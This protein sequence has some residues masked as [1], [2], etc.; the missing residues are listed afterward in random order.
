MTSTRSLRLSGILLA[1]VALGANADAI[2]RA[3]SLPVTRPEDVGLSG[4][5]L[6][7]IRSRLQATLV[8]SGRVPGFVVA[9][10]RHG[11]LVY[12]D[13]LGF[14]DIDRRVPMRPNTVFRIFSMTKPITSVAVLQLAEQGRLRLDDPVAKY[15]PAFAR[16]RVRVITGGD[17][18][19]VAP[20]RAVTVENLLTHTSGL[21]Y[22]RALQLRSSN[23]AAFADSIDVIPL[24]SQP[25]ERFLY[26]IA[27]DVLGR[28]VEVASG[29]RFD[30]YLNDAIF[31]QLRMNETAFHAT[32]AMTERM[33]VDYARAP[34]GALRA[35]ATL[36]GRFYLP[37]SDMFLGGE[38]LLST[39]PD[40]LR[41]TQMLLNGGEL[42]GVRILSRES[43]GR[44]LQNHLPAT[45]TSAV[46]SVVRG[47]VVGQYGFGYGGAVR[48]DSGG[49][50]PESPGTY[51]WAGAH[52]TYFW[53]DPKLDLAVLVW[54]QLTP[55]SLW[56]P[57]RD[58]ERLVYAAV[59]R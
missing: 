59:L 28:V 9:V 14:A 31:S 2:A 54:T 36:L 10:A 30:R 52:S 46:A 20:S 45:F 51:R 24:L 48:V 13:T 21:P 32:P 15:V 12:L 37:E 23:L 35:P 11:K 42:D 29:K 43:V 49:A 5:V 34:D 33:V 53:I 38:G 44:M 39:V 47:Y 7:G 57:E 17:T 58:V 41:F 18:S 22:N 27:H 26:S 25:G 8:D 19:Y 4:S 55:N 3:Q 40:Y 50:A 16:M 6:K 1:V 56:F